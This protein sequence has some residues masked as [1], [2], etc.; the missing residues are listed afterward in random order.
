MRVRI[1]ETPGQQELDGVRLDGFLRGMVRDVSTIMGAWLITEG[2]AQLEMRSS[3]DED[4][5][6]EPVIP[7]GYGRAD[8]RNHNRR[9]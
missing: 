9:G 5:Q 2:Y 4:Q 1:T 8:R 3:P 6:H 7:F